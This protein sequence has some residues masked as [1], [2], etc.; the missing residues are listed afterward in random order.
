MGYSPWYHLDFVE[1]MAENDEGTLDIL[2]ENGI[3]YEVPRRK[4]AFNRDYAVGD[5]N[6]VVSIKERYANKLGLYNDV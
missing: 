4:I 5:K 1:I 6:G 3:I 2:A